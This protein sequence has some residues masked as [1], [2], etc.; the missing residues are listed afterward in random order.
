MRTA[1]ASTSRDGGANAQRSHIRIALCQMLVSDDKQVSLDTASRM[2]A[3]A[4][5]QQAELVVLPECFNCP[6]DT[7]CFPQYAEVLP[8]A[9]SEAP[10]APAT[11]DSSTVARLRQL[12]RQHQVHL[13]GGSVPERD[14]HTGRLYNT[15][16]SFAPDGE[17]IAK[18]RKMHLFD[19]DVPDGIR[20]RESDA[21]SA[22]SALTTFELQPQGRSQDAPSLR[23]GIGIC[24]DMRFSEMATVLTRPPHN[25]RL[26]IYPG[27]FNMTTGPAHWELILRARALDNQVW[28]AACS[29]ARDL[30][31]SYTAYGHSLVVSPWGEVVARA[32]EKPAVI[33]ADADM[34][35]LTRV[36][37]MIP[38]SRQRRD[39]LYQVR[40]VDEEEAS[41]VDPVD[42]SGN[43]AATLDTKS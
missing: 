37:Y 39:D 4:A 28:V 18:H 31:A 10:A 7:Q 2:V 6:Y 40:A 22:G 43:A 1:M 26:L 34:S 21:L 11:E 24:Y 3:E 5:A 42:S 29:P 9:P 36:R 33:V 17:L 27:A 30:H 16:L 8:P 38:L 32:D 20:F 12:A 23:V 19:V 25:A 41:V 15:S 14:P 13:V 35:L